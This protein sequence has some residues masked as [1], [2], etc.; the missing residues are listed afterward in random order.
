MRITS[1]ILAFIFIQSAY[2]QNFGTLCNDGIESIRKKEYQKAMTH[3]E[4]AVIASEDNGEKLYAL[5]NLAFSCQMVGKFEKAIDN[6]SKALLIDK[7][8]ITLLQ[9]RAGIYM[10]LDSAERAIADYSLVLEKEPGNTSALLHRAHIYTNTGQFGK[11][12]G[13]YHRLMSIDPEE[14][15]TRLGYARLY[16]KEKRYNECL[17]L[18]GLL[19]EDYPAMAEL[20]I[21]RSDVSREMGQTEL[22]LMDV[23]KAIELEPENTNHYKLQSIL[24]DMLGKKEAAEKSRRTANRLMNRE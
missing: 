20:Y 9:Q 14:C 17:M 10:F 21:A 4:K 6:Y 19:I 3:F 24:F 2:S 1:A 12:R 18:L 22:A 16:Q 23:D 11:A 8:D 13:D 15:N 5:A 7:H